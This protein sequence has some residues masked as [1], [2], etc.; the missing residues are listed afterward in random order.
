MEKIG[1]RLK[2]K[3]ERWRAEGL[4]PKFLEQRI[5]AGSLCYWSSA[6]SL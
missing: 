1:E 2:E 4:R 3:N 6:L 5:D